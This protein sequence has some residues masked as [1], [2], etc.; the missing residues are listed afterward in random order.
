MPYLFGKFVW[1]ENASR[2]PKAAQAFY[3]ELFGWKVDPSP[4]GATKYDRIMAGGVGIGGYH[5]LDAKD[6][7]PAHWISYL[8]VPDVDKGLAAAKA[9][10]AKVVV[11]AFDIPTVGRMGGIVDPQGAALML[12]HGADGDNA[13]DD[14]PAAGRWFWNELWVADPAA[15]ATFY[16]KAFGYAV[17]EMDMGPA[18]TY[19]VLE[20]DGVSRAGIM[21][22]PKGVPAM[23]LPYAA[24]DDCD[25][26]VARARKLG[27]K[28]HFEPTDI[29]DIGRFAVLADP[30]GAAIAAIKPV[31][32]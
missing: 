13:T 8:S 18:G 22:S 20:K 28:V 14:P 3:G 10:G 24:V 25:A 6:P 21:A 31:S 15:A 1:F 11:E 9:A 19:R 23:W 2:D 4:M 17:K 29:P 26:T 32:R 12:F 5:A 16:E 27:G 30:Q 7:R